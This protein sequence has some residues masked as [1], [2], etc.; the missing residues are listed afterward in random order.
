MALTVMR[1]VQGHIPIVLC[2]VS[3]PCQ[4]DHP[5]LGTTGGA[6]LSGGAA[7]E[8]LLAP[9]LATAGAAVG[10]A[11]APFAYQAGKEAATGP[12]LILAR[13]AELVAETA[14]QGG[15]GGS[16]GPDTNLARL[17]HQVAEAA[18][19]GAAGLLAGVGTGPPARCL[20]SRSTCA[21]Q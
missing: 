21:D 15:E 8:V 9:K 16:N 13:V 18:G 3:R 11:V 17:G 20:D 4:S 10:Q 7:A 1:E 19:R 5:S 12:T 2:G 6:Y 14:D